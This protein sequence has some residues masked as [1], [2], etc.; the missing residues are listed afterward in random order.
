MLLNAS[1]GDR[2]RQISRAVTPGRD[3][4]PRMECMDSP[5]R[6]NRRR[7]QFGLGTLFLV[8]TLV[9]IGAAWCG[10]Q[11]GLVHER[12]KLSAYIVAHGGSVYSGLELWGEA[13]TRPVS[14]F[15]RWLGDEAVGQIYLPP[16]EFTEG[17]FARVK[18]AFP[19]ANVF[20]PKSGRSS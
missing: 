4:G 20:P 7:W 11:L 19:E 10:W 5:S 14:W 13:G 6:T 1:V 15:R 9:A 18:H 16:P 8:F 2:R 17:D 3:C 12:Q